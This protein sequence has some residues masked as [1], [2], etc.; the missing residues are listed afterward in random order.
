VIGPVTAL[1][2]QQTNEATAT[3]GYGPETASASDPANY[4]GGVLSIALEKSVSVD[5]GVTYHDA[6]D[7]TGPTATVGNDV[8]FKFVITNTGDV[9]LTNVTLDDSVFDFSVETVTTSESYTLSG[10]AIVFDNDLA[11]AGTFEVVIGPIIALAGQHTNTATAVG[12]DAFENPAPQASDPANYFGVLLSIDLEK[13]VSVVSS[14]GPWE[15]A[16]A[17][18]GPQV[19]A[20]ENVWFQFVVTNTSNVPLYHI[21]VTDSDFDA[22]GCDNAGPLAPG[23]SYS[24]VIGPFPAV[25]GPHVN[26]ATATGEDEEGN[27]TV[28]APDPANYLGAEPLIDLEKHVS[29][30]GGVTYHDADAAPGPTV[31]EG[32]DVYFRF[33]VTN[34]GNV[35]LYDLTLVDTDFDVSGCG[36]TGPLAPGDFYACVIGPFPAALGLHTNTAAATGEDAGGNLAPEASDPAN[37]TGEP[38]G[39][40]S[41][42]LEKSVSVDG[43]LTYQDA[44]DA[45]GPTAIVGSDVYLKFVVTNTGDVTLTNVTLDDN[46][47]DF[48]L[49]PVFVCGDCTV[50]GGDILFTNDLAPG[51][52]FVVVI[53]PI[54]AVSD[55]HTNEGT[56]TGIYEGRTASASDPANYLGAEPAIDVEKYL[57]LVSD[58]GPWDDADT[59][60]GPQVMAGDSVW[61]RFVVENTGNVTLTNITLTDTDFDLSSCGAIPDLAPGDT[62]ECVIGPF[63]STGLAHTNTATASGDYDGQTVEDDDSASYAGIYWAF[64]PGFWKNNTNDKGQKSHDAWKYTQYT[65]DVLLGDVFDQQCLS[66]YS[67]KRGKNAK[68]FD[69][70]TLLE[71]LSFKGGEDISGAM[72]ILLRAAVASLL[73]ASF[74]EEMGNEIGYGGVYPYTTAE[75]IALVNEALCSGDRM[76]M[77]T[78]YEQLDYIN[79][80]IHYID[81]SW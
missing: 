26:T 28:S 48:S 15:D 21:T 17:A 35:D 25:V 24:C 30:D 71:A 53:G 50:V 36:N 3:G 57:S 2:G 72:E 14:T 63:A 19:L 18:P 80:G 34:T 77:L 81:W 76:A 4:F 52:S 8:Y 10:D 61:F 45:P 70:F 23:D 6:D 33:V 38:A 44:D 39:T 9:T 47:F 79:N 78:L 37:Y 65:T 67:P 7:P 20:G 11:P 5:D 54:T 55:Q 69:E 62:F 51:V 29:V 68:T 41:I 13:S 59:P 27:K 64:T 43:G 1:A 12:E 46:V 22:S 75:V 58:S 56:A 40:P 16:D 60:P 74:H 32:S 66:E 49:V 31:I 73:N 42:D